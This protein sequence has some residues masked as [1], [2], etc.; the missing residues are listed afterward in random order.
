MSE[1]EVF[2]CPFIPA[3]CYKEQCKFWDP[4]EED[5]LLCDL[6]LTLLLDFL[7]EE[8]RGRRK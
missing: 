4:E 6:F 8:R 5:C 7:K 2:E 3:P 1:K